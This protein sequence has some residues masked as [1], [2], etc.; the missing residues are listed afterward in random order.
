MQ[1]NF[2][3]CWPHARMGVASPKHILDNSE[4]KISEA[5]L[6]KQESEYPTSALLHD[7]VILPSESRK[8]SFHVRTIL[9]VTI[10]PFFRLLNSV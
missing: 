9:T 4:S 10:I 7:G 6:I 1:P 8:V 5:E 2:L 3:F